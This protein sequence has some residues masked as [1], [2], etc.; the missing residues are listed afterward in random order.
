MYPADVFH[1]YSSRRYLDQRTWKQR[2]THAHHN[3]ELVLSSLAESYME[4]KYMPSASSPPFPAV[5][6]PPPVT[7]PPRNYNFSLE[8]LDIY[9]LNT[10]VIIPCSEEELPIQALTKNGYLGNTPTTP[11]LAI[12]FRTL[13]LLRRIRLRK[14][15]FSVEAFVKVVCVRKLDLS[16]LCLF[17]E[18]FIFL[19]SSQFPSMLPLL[20]YSQSFFSLSADHPRHSRRRRSKISILLIQE[21]V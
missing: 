3:W 7:S 18:L 11:S 10:L 16:H 15:S 4:W 5:A 6:D 8:V 19:C 1:R 20:T 14:S 17:F 2:I 12:S 9:T 13:E 21:T